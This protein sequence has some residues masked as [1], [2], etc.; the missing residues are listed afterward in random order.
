MRT[1]QA[2]SIDKLCVGPEDLESSRKQHAVPRH[3]RVPK[4][5]I[6][7]SMASSSNIGKSS[8]DCEVCHKL[9][10][11]AERKAPILRDLRASA[12]S[13]RSCAIVSQALTHFNETTYHDAKVMLNSN[14]RF[15]KWARE[16]VLRISPSPDPRSYEAFELFEVAGLS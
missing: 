12:G 7:Y 13:C 3:V 15:N 11:D 6:P 9:S 10:D 2:S 5:D 8:L 14:S 16:I 1:N 4:P